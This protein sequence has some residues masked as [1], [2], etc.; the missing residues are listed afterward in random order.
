MDKAPYTIPQ[1]VRDLAH[2]ISPYRGQFFVG[3]FFRFTSD[4]AR[5][6]PA[7]A[8]SR[9]ILLLS[10]AH[11]F[12]LSN[13]LL[14]I[15]IIWG[16]VTVY[17]GF[18]HNFSKFNG[19]QVAE[20]ASLTLYKDCLAHIFKLDFAWQETENS[21]NKMKRIDKGL[22]GV[23]QTIRRIFDVLIEVAVNTIGIIVI[24]FTLDKGLSFA[25]LFFMITYFLLGTTLLKRAVRQEQVVNKA[26]ENLGGLTYEALNNI[27]TI[28]SL[29]IHT[30]V[31]NAVTRHIVGLIPKIRNRIF[32]FQSQQALL[33][34]YEALFEF[35][36][37]AFLTWG[38]VHGRNDVSLLV[39]FIGLFQKVSEST[40]ELTN[41]TQELALSKIWVSRAMDILRIEPTVEHPNRVA[42]QQVYPIDWKE[43]K[44]DN[45]KFSYKKSKTLQN[46][47]LTIKRGEKVG[48]VGLSGAGK[49]T[50]FKLLLDLYE[51]YEG[52][53]LIGDIPLKQ[54]KRQS[55]ID[56][57]AVVLQ[58]TE[59]FDMTLQEN[60]EISAVAG[61]PLST[62][63]LKEVITMSHL[64]E[65]VAQLPEGLQTI[66]G[67]KGIKL[68]GGQ[69][70]RVGIARALY[71]QP[72]ILLLDEATSH[73]DARSEKEIQRALQENMQ[74]FTTI[75]IAHRL[76]TIK[77]MD[78]IVVLGQGKIIEQGSFD[79]LLARDGAFARMWHEQKI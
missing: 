59:L 9:V 56:H 10:R 61:S 23:N 73:L 34:M 75:V 5:L 30:G 70:Q 27:Q 49:S 54:M 31:N 68:S 74:K 47:S 14:T 12:T 26:F 1:F 67:E 41:V 20:K 79:D 38:I 29:A 57:V 69:R 35:G 45:V 63:F 66:V 78:K 2:Y 39:L 55:F 16:L 65:V 22:E 44:I 71:R 76:S 46:I 18:A 50:L 36:I 64:E 11:A 62:E 58:D 21:G 77:A 51:D 53:I 60:I 7:W 52:E 33:R 17:Y 25:L 8:I 42:R 72:D 40:S 15:F 28:K 43:I 4:L 24:F 3:L 48:I 32:L 6:F 13:E 19:Y 37:I